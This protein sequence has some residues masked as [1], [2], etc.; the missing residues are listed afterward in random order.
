MSARF[1][2]SLLPLV[3]LFGVPNV[4]CVSPRN[5]YFFTVNEL[6]L[7]FMEN[8]RC[9]NL[10]IHARRESICMRHSSSA[11]SK[12]AATVARFEQIHRMRPQSSSTSRHLG[13]RLR[14]RRWDEQLGRLPTSY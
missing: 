3:G 5:L 12:V 1:S 2:V 13:R 10:D 14:G 8:E 7:A 9:L 11:L 6:S 4:G